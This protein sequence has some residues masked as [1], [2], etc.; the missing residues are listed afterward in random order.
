VNQSIQFRPVTTLLQLERFRKQ[1]PSDN[2]NISCEAERVS[3]AG[4]MVRDVGKL[5]A[6]MRLVLAIAFFCASLSVS[7]PMA[8]ASSDA[9]GASVAVLKH[10]HSPSG[11]R[12]SSNSNASISEADVQECIPDGKSHYGHGTSSSDCCAAACFDLTILSAV[13]YRE[14]VLPPSLSDELRRSVL[15]VGPYRFLRPPRT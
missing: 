6:L 10:D 12:I 13:G 5:T 14:A 15:A 9:K 2:G 7:I 8:E 4:I 3:L 1:P 11:E